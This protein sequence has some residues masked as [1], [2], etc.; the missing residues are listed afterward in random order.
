MPHR[1]WRRRDILYLRL[2]WNNLPFPHLIGR[3]LLVPSESILNFFTGSLVIH[4]VY[5]PI[6]GEHPAAFPA[7]VA[8]EHILFGVEVELSFFLPAE[9]TVHIKTCCIFMPDMQV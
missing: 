4:P 8:F 5:L 2:L 1:I 7:P 3:R 6:Q 9:R